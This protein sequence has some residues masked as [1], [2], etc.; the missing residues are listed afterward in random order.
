PAGCGARANL[1]SPPL[2]ECHA[3]RRGSALGTSLLPCPP[4]SRLPTGFGPTAARRLPAWRSCCAAPAGKDRP[5]DLV[6]SVPPCPTP[7]FSEWLPSH[8]QRR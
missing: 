2:W 3:G 8:L 6:S 4:W 7:E 5:G 1:T